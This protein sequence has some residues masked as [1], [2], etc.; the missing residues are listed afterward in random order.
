MFNFSEE[1]KKVPD[2][3]GVYIMKDEYDRIIYVGKAKSLKKRLR[4][5]FTEST[6]KSAKVRLMVENIKEFEYIIVHNEIESLILEN[7][8]I[9][10]NEPKYNILLKDDKQYPYIKI[11]LN[12]K[13]PR[14]LKVRK[15][16]KDGA[17]YYGPFPSA[18]AVNIAIDYFHDIYPLR[19]CSL[20]FD[21]GFTKRRPCL[22]YFINRCYA[23]CKGD[24]DEDKYMENVKKVIQ[25]LD[26]KD[27]SIIKD[28]YEKMKEQSEKL[29]YEEAIV[30]RD[31]INA[32]EVL[33]KKQIADSADFADQDIIAMARGVD[34]ICIQIFFVRMGKIVGREHFI[35]D[36]PLHDDQK[37][38]LSTFVKQFYLGSAYVP[39]EII[40]ENYPEDTTEIENWLSQK[41]GKR[42]NILVPQ[43]GEKV[44]ILKLVQENSEEM[45]KKYGQRF[46]KKY[47]ENM[48]TLEQLMDLLGLKKLPQRI[49]CYDISHI[50]G[51]EAVGSMV[52][53]ENGEMKKS[54]YRKFRIKT[55]RGGDDYAAMREVLERRFNRYIAPETDKRKS[56]SKL[57]DLLIVDGGKG[58]INSAKEVMKK[59]DL[60]VEICGLVKDEFHKTRGLIYED[61]EY[62]MPVSTNL[63][64]LLYKIQDE[65]H[66]FAIGFHRSRM[67]KKAFRSELDDIKGIGPKRKNALLDH[68]KGIEAIKNA[69][70]D[71]LKK[72]DGMNE[73][74]AI[75]LYEHFNGRR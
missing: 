3:P 48:N 67:A 52:V 1:L 57:P 36:D 23:P 65:A 27:D 53:F 29:E 70:I 33:T 8:L 14:V 59:F 10:G 25:F 62:K 44:R 63:Y 19:S 11:T 56:F 6:K 18:Y 15:V 39:Q 68:F 21:K 43:R 45:L 58:Q 75:S 32:L 50:S 4:Q 37:T 74:A 13:Y 5:Y 9:K 61:N 38:I 31:T 69:S 24:V 49:E 51:V 40:L 71:E 55:A 54:D 42:V 17:K 26:G 41:K 28:L 35:L 73:P 30:T 2:Q 46:M 72:V 47:R 34:E 66:R 12:E 64:R 16:L 7:N 60:D 20:N 22:N